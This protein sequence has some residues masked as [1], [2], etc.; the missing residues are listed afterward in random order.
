MPKQKPSAWQAGRHRKRQLNFPIQRPEAGTPANLDEKIM[1][2]V[3]E[4][5]TSVLPDLLQQAVSRLSESQKEASSAAVNQ[6]PTLQ[7]Q[8]PFAHTTQQYGT[9]LPR[10]NLTGTYVEGF[11]PPRSHRGP[12]ATT[13]LRRESP[14]FQHV[15][16]LMGKDLEESDTKPNIQVEG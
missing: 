13:L 11:L 6:Q 4:T 9:T 10:Q 14:V 3:S 15:Q 5:V 2:C 1:T 12:M 7:P 16:V 8:P